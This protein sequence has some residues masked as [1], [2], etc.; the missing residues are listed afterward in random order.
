[1]RLII[2]FLHFSISTLTTAQNSLLLEGNTTPEYD[3]LITFYMEISKK[4]DD[5]ALYN[6][7]Y[8]DF[9][10]PI[11]VCVLGAVKDSLKTFENARNGNCLLVNNAIH[12]GEPCGVNASM[13]L[14]YDYTQL[15]KSAKKD[16]PIVAIIPM[17]NIGGA[18]NRSST[19]RANQIGPEEYGFRGNARNLDLNRDFIKMDSKNAWTFSRIFH[20]LDP[21]VFIDTHTS[22][23]ADY[24]HTMTYIA[25]IKGRFDSELSNLVYD[26]LLPF[27]AT[28]M[29]DQWNYD[30]IP[31][32]SMN[33]STLDKGIHAFNALP[34]YASGYAELFNTLAITTETHMLKPFE[35][36]VKST[37]AFIDAT[38]QWMVIHHAE[39]A[40]KREA[41]FDRQK[42]LQLLPIRY[43]L[44]VNELDSLFLKGFEWE[45]KNSEL[46]E[47]QRLFYDRL[48]PRDMYIPFLQTYL[49][50][51]TLQIPAYIIIGQQETAIIDRLKMNNVSFQLLD[52]PITVDGVQFKINDFETVKS[53]YE[54]HYLHSNINVEPV[55]KSYTARKGD[56]LIPVRQRNIQ[57]LLHVLYPVNEDSYFAWNFFDS[58]LQQKEY[59]SDYVF[60]EKAIQFLAEHPEVAAE[61]RKK[62]Q[63][64]TAFASSRWQQM[65]WI[66]QHTA[67]YE[68][69]THRIL[70]LVFV[71]E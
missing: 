30:L 19:S 57:F 68:Q 70:P 53:P 44:N 26:N 34:R 37:Y 4:H 36:R 23:G 14:V 35:D 25:P 32:V 2:L 28:S 12:P 6:M 27:V 54:G 29:T 40:A 60:E 39:L 24:Q 43:Q 8:S 56:V 33:G 71:Y 51:D 21:D 16:W 58:Y 65:S 69:N 52:A 67:Y 55:Q 62:Q 5:I 11:Y 48:K 50:M 63:E 49:A 41:A 22:N 9:G 66:Y 59:F 7:G 3:E 64:E 31:Y 13:Q 61:F 18:H 10:K 15:Q 17:Y 20:A 42:N 38:I 46:T 1:M 47:Q 45:L